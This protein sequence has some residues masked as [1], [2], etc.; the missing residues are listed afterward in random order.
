MKD[1]IIP[2]PPGTK[3]GGKIADGL[4]ICVNN[5]E[6]CAEVAVVRIM[7]TGEIAAYC[8]G[9]VTL[10]KCGGR[11]F[12]GSVRDFPNRDKETALALAWD[13]GLA[14][15]PQEYIDLF[16]KSWGASLTNSKAQNHE[17][18]IPENSET[19]TDNPEDQPGTNPD[20]SPGKT[21]ENSG[22][23]GISGPTDEEIYN[24]LYGG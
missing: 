24:D 12:S 6:S 23:S 13:L 5:P 22:N 9:K 19:S 4:T 21:A 2:L 8:D 1:Q 10:R 17:S 16:E 14:D 18:N 15:A 3:S 7:K 20:N 11:K